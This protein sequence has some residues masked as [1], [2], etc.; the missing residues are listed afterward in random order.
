MTEQKI[1]TLE[2]DT[3][4]AQ[5]RELLLSAQ[6]PAATVLIGAGVSVAAGI[7]LAREIV[8]DAHKQFSAFCKDLDPN[9]PNSYGKT[10][11]R[12]SP[13]Q[14]RLLLQAYFDTAKLNWG[15]I[16]LAHLM[17]ENLVERVLTVNF[18]TILAR[19]CGLLGLY[20]AI[21]DF[22]SAPV[23]NV[24]SMAVPAI[25]HLHGQ[26]FGFVQ[27]TSEEE[28]RQHAQKL[29]PV[30]RESVQGRPLIIIGYSGQSDG[31]MEALTKCYDDNTNLY[32]VDLSDAPPPHVNRCFGAK[33]YANF[34]GGTDADRFLVRLAQE[35]GG[36][37]PPGNWTPRIFHDPLSHLLDE[38][39]PVAEF[40]VGRDDQKDDI[41]SAW[42]LDIRKLREEQR[43]AF[44]FTRQAEAAAIQGDA[45]LA[46]TKAMEATAAGAPE[47]VAQKRIYQGLILEGMKLKEASE[48]VDVKEAIATLE[49][50]IEA[51]SRA[52][53][54]DPTP[55]VALFNW[56]NAL[57]AM[58]RLSKGE[59]RRELLIQ[60][61]QKYEAAIN[62]ERGLHEAWTNW[63]TTFAE[64]Y[65]CSPNAVGSGELL[66]RAEGCF[67]E[68]VKIRD[69]GQ[70]ALSNWGAILFLMAKRTDGEQRD[71]L[72]AR[73]SEKL[74]AAEELSPGAGAYNLACI[75]ILKNEEMEARKWLDRAAEF[76]R[77]PAERVLKSDED[78]DAVR[79][80]KWFPAV[81]EKARRKST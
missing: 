79:N 50:A 68:S 42:R 53:R 9:E 55:H 25:I 69:G 38:M 81:L 34:V 73:A 35:I 1:Q 63:G 23:A 70:R 77:L 33:A 47:A 8:R 43:D 36:A 59:K 52:E 19:A 45:R 28:T 54:K 27:L 57:V 60:A 80:A 12:L 7:P 56:G 18:D 58:A 64:L 61:G 3:A 24:K 29:A 31:V 46:V 37:R 14:R 49:R 71:E 67:N 16:A 44:N 26:S 32:W 72:L 62:L 17:N 5:L 75:M 40:P 51:Y 39:A 22:G 15:H 74:K 13:P 4:V 21:Y 30:V 20:P 10:M 2:A 41:L 65:L 76:N 11:A 48:R 66:V 6:T 78:L